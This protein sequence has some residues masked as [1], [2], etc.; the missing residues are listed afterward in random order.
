MEQLLKQDSIFFIVSDDYI[1]YLLKIENHVMKNKPEERTY[2]RKYEYY[3]SIE[4]CP[5]RRLSPKSYWLW[6]AFFLFSVRKTH[7]RASFILCKILLYQ[8]FKFFLCACNSA[9][10]KNRRYHISLSAKSHS[11]AC[12]MFCFRRRSFF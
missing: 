10:L 2:H 11:F 3:C 6:E 5:S 12:K 9:I 7:F 8:N 1:D 4:N